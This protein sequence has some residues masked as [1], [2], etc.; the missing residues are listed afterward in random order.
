V[1]TKE[2]ECNSN[3]TF[4]S[5]FKF[6]GGKR[7]RRGCFLQG[8][9]DLLRTVRSSR[10]SWFTN[11]I[12]GSGLNRLEWILLRC[13]FIRARKSSVHACVHA[14]LSWDEKLVFMFVYTN[15]HSRFN[16][17]SQTFLERS[18]DTRVLAWK[19]GLKIHRTGLYSKKVDGVQVAVVDRKWGAKCNL[20][21]TL[22]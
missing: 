4:K 6:E 12:F 16:S 20:V 19:I 5:N 2:L 15:H 1:R 22:R 18:L 21:I 17:L 11:K 8:I 13:H 10:F 7:Y 9:C 14:N 3:Q